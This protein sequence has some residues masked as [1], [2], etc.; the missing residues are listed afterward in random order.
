M[1][2]Y[3]LPVVKTTTTLG[4]ILVQAESVEQANQLHLTETELAHL[5]QVHSLNA[6]LYEKQEW[7]AGYQQLFAP[8][9][10]DIS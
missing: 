7:E 6:H 10:T 1:K 8:Q 3:A 9:G 4:H 2:T 5:F